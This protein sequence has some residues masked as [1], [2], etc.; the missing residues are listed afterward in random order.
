MPGLGKVRRPFLPSLAAGMII[1]DSGHLRHVL[2]YTGVGRLPCL[3]PF[4]A[5]GNH[6]KPLCGKRRPQCSFDG[7]LNGMVSTGGQAFGLPRRRAG[8]RTFGPDEPAISPPASASIGSTDDGVLYRRRRGRQPGCRRRDFS[9]ATSWY[10][11]MERRSTAN[12]LEDVSK[13]IRGAANTS[14]TLV[15]RRDGEDEPLPSNAIRSMYR[16]WPAR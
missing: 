13:R 5:L 16:P 12:K 15:V 3:N 6:R 1:M 8:A 14:V 7:A 4:H 2:H 9:A 11:S 10:L